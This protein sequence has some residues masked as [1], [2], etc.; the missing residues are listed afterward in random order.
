[1]FR[2]SSIKLLGILLHGMSSFRFIL[3][4]LISFSFSISVILGTVGIMDGFDDALKIGLRRASG[5]L[6]IHSRQGYFNFE[7][8]LQGKLSQS[9]IEHYTS[10]IQTEGFLVHGESSRGVVIKGIE[11]SSFSQ[12]SGLNIQLKENEIVL[13]QE[14]QKQLGIKKG[15]SIVIVLANGN[16]GLSSLPLLKRFRVRMFVEHG[17]Y[18]KD[19][20]FVYVHKKILQKSLNLRNWVN[21]VSVNIPPKV[22][23]EDVETSSDQYLDNI[24]D[25]ELK[26]RKLLESHFVLKP[27]WA[28]FD[29]LIEAVQVEK[30]TIS[31]IL[32]LIVIISIFNVLSFIIFLNEKRAKE[33][34]LFQALGV[35]KKDLL[36]VWLYL[37]FF[38]W[39]ISCLFSIILAQIFDFGLQHLP[40]LQ[41]PGDIYNLGHLSLKLSFMDY[42][43]VFALALFW[44]F[45]IAMMGIIRINRKSILSG[46]R[47]EFS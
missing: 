39:V 22:K 3:G 36:I 7:K 47:K 41:L 38:I 46:L 19:L 12:V 23:G 8:D 32:Q 4:V 37:I 17:I 21:L 13:G 14:L 10:M 45:V 42:F 5:D 44:I 28:E 35:S 30:F 29:P 6:L 1:M 24:K 16:G 34:F 9:G 40:F 18:K 20:R 43:Y 15:D 2:P 31:L 27:F 11:P 33:I 26:I 25:Y